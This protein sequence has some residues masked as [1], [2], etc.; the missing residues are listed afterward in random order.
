MIEVRNLSKKYDDKT[1]VYNVSLKIEKGKWIRKLQ[2][3]Q[4][5]NKTEQRSASKR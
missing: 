5:T 4:R 3:K 1:V 2:R